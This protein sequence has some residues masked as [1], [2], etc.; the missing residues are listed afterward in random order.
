MEGKA[1]TIIAFECLSDLLL[2]TPYSSPSI[3][4]IHWETKKY[5]S[6]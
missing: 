1:L 2:S 6:S 4:E 3:Y 5:N